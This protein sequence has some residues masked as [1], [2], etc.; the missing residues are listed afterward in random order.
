MAVGIEQGKLCISSVIV[1][2]NGF[3]DFRFA[4][5]LA[6]SRLGFDVKR[7]PEDSGITQANFEYILAHEY[8]VF[9][10]ITGVVD[11]KVVLRECRQAIDNCLPIFIFIKANN[12]KMSKKTIDYM[13]EISKVAFAYDCT[14]FQTCEELYRQVDDRLRRYLNRKNKLYPILQSDIAMAYSLNAELMPKV[15]KQIIVCQ[16]TSILILGP[17][18]N[19]EYEINFYKILLDW[20]INKDPSMEFLHV[21]SKTK[22]LQ[23]IRQHG[24]CY[25]LG[26]AKR[27][28]ETL[29]TNQKVNLFI[30]TTKKESVSYVITDTNLLLVLPIEEYKYTI[31]LPSYLMKNSEVD[32]IKHVLYRTSG[33]FGIDNIA[34]YY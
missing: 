20:L 18:K 6:A 1:K 29:F 9:I 3:Q 24:N 25:D 2:E 31:N 14:L 15:K 32:K 22:T 17:R 5:Y 23:E 28:L 19:I 27:N 7:N 10:L 11:S 16:Q 33:K 34:E 13:N 21:F 26:L 12:G 4:A 30:G 8:P